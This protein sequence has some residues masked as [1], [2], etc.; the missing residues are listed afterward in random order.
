V[1][2]PRAHE[3]AILAAAEEIDAVEQQ[4]RAAVAEGRT[5]AEARRQLGYHR[6]QARKS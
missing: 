5:L 4:I 3:E 2:L 1:V 6:L